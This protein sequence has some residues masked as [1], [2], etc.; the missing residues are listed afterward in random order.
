MDIKIE[1]MLEKL[2]QVKNNANK[3]L[4]GK[5]EYKNSVAQN[6]TYYGTI[7][8]VNKVFR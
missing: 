5:E 1:E 8:L 3:D 4:E 6:V 7:E 2:R